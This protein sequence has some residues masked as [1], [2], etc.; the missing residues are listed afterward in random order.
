MAV[1]IGVLA[2]VG[3]G[4]L[5]DEAQFAAVVSNIR[6]RT[7]GATLVGLT[8]CPEDT[9]QRHGVAAFPIRRGWAPYARRRAAASTNSRVGS[10]DRVRRLV[11]AVPPL[12]RIVKW[13]LAAAGAVRQA[14]L[15]VPFLFRAY[16]Q[17]SSMSLLIV[18][19]S[20][21]LSEIKG[22][23]WWFPYTIFKWALLA[24]LRSVPVAIV[25]VGAGPF[26]SPLARW[27]TRCTLLIAAYGSFRDETS[28]ECVRSLGIR[29]PWPLAPDLAFS[30][31]SGLVDATP[32]LERTVS[33]NPMPTFLWQ[34]YDRITEQALY[35]KYVATLAEFAAWLIDRDYRVAFFATQMGGDPSA[36][37]DIMEGLKKVRPDAVGRG[38]AFVHAVDGF[39]DLLSGLRM[40]CI[41]V[42]TRF[43][44]AVLG[45]YAGRPVIALAAK[46]HTRD[47]MAQM[48]DAQYVVSAEEIRLEALQD[49]FLD[50]EQRRD[51]VIARRQGRLKAVQLQLSAQY[52]RLVELAHRRPGETIHRV[53]NAA[54]I[55]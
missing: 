49:A 28:R 43:H 40:A 5:G 53:Q 54:K 14:V 18:A 37:A 6:D 39:E 34:D 19:G 26:Y 21:Q 51:E 30:L 36:I 32:T 22:G 23:L 10:G 7:P 3:N 8:L 33:I 2:H 52:D 42:A 24:R 1:K 4:N 27:F 9:L 41:V 35:T 11:R 55:A 20:Q 15:E 38:R 50:L 44:A 12:F 17:L 48:G 45:C 47:L 31:R 46:A 13:G 25:S 29:E 16:R